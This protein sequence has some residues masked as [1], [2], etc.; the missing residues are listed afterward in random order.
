MR[1]NRCKI[2]LHPVYHHQCPL[3]REKLERKPRTLWQR[4]VSFALPL[5][6]Y[7][8]DGCGQILFAFSPYWTELPIFERV[9]RIA[10]TAVILLA[11]VVVFFVILFYIFS[12][13]MA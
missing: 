2:Y 13:I 10:A 4:A 6:H 12:M 9:L 11:A 3:C 5:R 1:I 8:C 7:E